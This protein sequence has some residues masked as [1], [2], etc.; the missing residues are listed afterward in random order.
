MEPAARHNFLC[1]LAV[2][3][4]A[5]WRGS[6]IYSIHRYYIYPIMFRGYLPCALHA[7][8]GSAQEALLGPRKGAARPREQMGS[9]KKERAQTK[10][11]AKQVTGTGRQAGPA[12]RGG[13]CVLPH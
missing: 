6:P 5:R 4:C 2:C 11:A 12:G 7:R 8:A 9:A 3:A 1:Y 10:R 13:R